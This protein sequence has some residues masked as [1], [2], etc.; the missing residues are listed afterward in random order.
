MPSTL[1]YAQAFERAF[2]ASQDWLSNDLRLA[3]IGAGYTPDRGAHEYWSDV[4]AN[5]LSAT[6]Y[7]A[8]GTALT[9]E[10]ISVT[11]ANSFATTWA[12]STAYAV[13]FIVRPTAGNGFLY[14]CSVAG[15]SSGSQP[16]WPTVIGTTVA[17]GG[18]TWTCVG[19][20][21]ILFTC[22]PTSIAWTFSGSAS[23]RYGVIYDRTPASDA[24]R[25]L[26]FLVDFDATQSITN[27]TFTVN[28]GT[29]CVAAVF[30][31]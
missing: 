25:P 12:A 11:P 16:T 28:L 18:V 22:S 26:M 20:F 10:G 1:W 15:T 3:L 27:A 14:S 13:G 6:G 2:D 30:V 8:N 29:Q 21:V 23:P 9:S 4:V 24:T 31:P 19:R 17:D 5:E 7:T